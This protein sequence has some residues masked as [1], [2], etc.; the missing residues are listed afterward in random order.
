MEGCR[1]HSRVRSLYLCLSLCLCSLDEHLYRSRWGA[2]DAA[3]KCNILCYIGNGE[4]TSS[5]HNAFFDAFLKA[6]NTHGDVVLS[7]DDVWMCICLQ[8]S[9]Y[10]CVCGCARV[11]VSICV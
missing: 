7:P 8:F 1:L 6:Y 9:K 3:C 11:R 4:V 5:S 10:M 2:K